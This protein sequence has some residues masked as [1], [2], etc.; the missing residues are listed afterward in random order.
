MKK[1]SNLLPMN[2]QFFAD[3]ADATETTTET[4]KETTAE[5]TAEVELTAEE[6][7]QQ[8]IMENAKLKKSFDKTSSE[9]AAY[10]KQLREK[11]SADEIS[12]QEKAEKELEKEEKL[13]QLLKENTIAKLEKG[14][15][16]LGYSGELATKAATAQ[17]ENDT[18]ELFKIQKE[19]QDSFAK[20]IEAEWLK[21]R[22]E[23]NMGTGESGSKV[24]KEEFDGYGYLQKVEFKQKNP[25]TYKKYTQHTQ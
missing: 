2:L 23:A 15:L 12:L 7:L 11:L 20:K 3:T 17:F 9:A 24:T 10:K 14:F 13:N 5:T 22:P 4:A 1:N 19:Y 21:N 25:L 8:L 18:D 16:T 6:K